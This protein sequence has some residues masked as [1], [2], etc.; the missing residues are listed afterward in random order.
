MSEEGSEI[1]EQPPKPIEEPDGLN[2]FVNHVNSYMGKSLISQLR[3]DQEVTKPEAAHKFVG[4]RDESENLPVPEGVAKIVDKN[5]T[6]SFRDQILASDVIVY[7]L[8]TAKFEE[9]D[10]VI[11][12]LKTNKLVETKTLILIS[13]VMTW[14]NTPPKFKKEKEEGEEEGEGEEEPEEEEPE[15]EE[16]GEGEEE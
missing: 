13:S 10:H 8:H 16:E 7:D 1:E 9:V 14:V 4:T 11:K 2:F 5:T 3:N 12:T 15:E 6:Q